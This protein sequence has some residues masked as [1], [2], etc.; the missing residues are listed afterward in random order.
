MGLKWGM[1]LK[2]LPYTV[3]TVHSKL[4]LAGSGT[5]KKCFDNTHD[6]QVPKVYL[7]YLSRLIRFTTQLLGVLMPSGPMNPLP[8]IYSVLPTDTLRSDSG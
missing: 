4:A 2:Y 1:P 8:P 5:V 6:Y 7:F 3:V